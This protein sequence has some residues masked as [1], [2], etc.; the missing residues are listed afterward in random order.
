MSKLTLPKGVSLWFT[1][2]PCSGKS[3]I[4]AALASFL[5]SK[6]IPVITLDGDEI[7]PIIGK[8]I[9]YT[10]A[11]REKV[12]DKYIDL[13]RIMI[14]TKAIT[15]VVVNNHT[16]AQ[17]KKARESLPA[18]QFI[19]I[20]VDTPLEICKERDVKGLYRAASKGEISNVVGVDI[21]YETPESYDI[22][23]TT[24]TESIETGC[25]KIFNFL[26]QRGLISI[27]Q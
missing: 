7:R 14:R 21:N 8:D 11:G 17:R 9:D 1:G 22:K 24:V 19:E 26:I 2:Y 18:A 23:I 20:W 4:A 6:A 27:E 3:T 25:Q 15:M 5:D 10:P 16:Q 13:C 12:L